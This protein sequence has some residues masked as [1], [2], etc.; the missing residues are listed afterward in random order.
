MYGE[1]FND[2]RKKYK[3]RLN[4]DEVINLL[5][6]DKVRIYIIENGDY[7]FLALI[8]SSNNDKLRSFYFNEQT[9]PYIIQLDKFSGVLF[10]SDFFPYKIK[11]FDNDLFLKGLTL[12]HNTHH[13]V[14]HI[15]EELK[16]QCDNSDLTN[17][18]KDGLYKFMYYLKQDFISE[19]KN[20]SIFMKEL[21][22]EL[23]TEFLDYISDD[24]KLV[25][26]QNKE[27]MFDEIFSNSFIE[28]GDILFEDV[29]IIINKFKGI[30]NLC[31]SPSL[32]YAL[33]NKSVDYNGVVINEQE[34]KRLKDYIFNDYC[35]EM[36]LKNLDY[37]SLKILYMCFSNEVIDYLLDDEGLIIIE[38]NNR[39]DKLLSNVIPYDELTKSK[40]FAMLLSKNFTD[41]QVYDA[42]IDR[43]GK[44]FSNGESF[45]NLLN[46]YI[47]L[48]DYSHFFRVFTKLSANT[49][50]FYFKNNFERLLELNNGE[51]CKG[52][53]KEVY[54]LFKDRVNFS[55]YVFSS[56]DL[57]VLLKHKDS[58]SLEQLERIFSNQE[59]IFAILNGKYI[60][61]TYEMI[62]N[63]NISKLNQIYMSEEVL[64]FLRNSNKLGRIYEI[65]DKLEIDASPLLL[66][67]NCLI[68]I[69]ETVEN[70]YKKS[71]LSGFNKFPQRD[72]GNAY[73]YFLLRIPNLKDDNT[74]F[75]I[76]DFY[77][78]RPK[79]LSTFHILRAGVK[80]E[81]L[82]EYLIS[83]RKLITEIIQE[84]NCD[85][86]LILGRLPDDIRK[87]EF[88]KG[89]ENVAI[90]LDALDYHG[91]FRDDFE[92]KYKLDE[93][94]LEDDRFIEKFIGY[95]SDVEESLRLV[96][97]DE[98]L[99]KKMLTKVKLYS[100]MKNKIARSLNDSESEFKTY[101]EIL[102]NSSIDVYGIEF[103]KDMIDVVFFNKCVKEVFFKYKNMNLEKIK[104]EFLSNVIKS[105]RE[106]IASS[107][108]NP[109]DKNIVYM[110]YILNG[111]K[112]LIPTIIYDSETYTFLVRRMRSGKHFY[113][114]TYKGG[115][116]YYSTITEKNRSMYYGETGVKFGYVRVIPEDIIQVNSF[117]A[118]SR[119]S[120]SNKYIAPYIKYPEWVSMEELNK[121]T[122]KSRSYNE[123]RIKEKY[124]PDFV[125][126][127]DEPNEATLRYSNEHS[128]PMVKILRK[129]YPGAIEQCKDPY[130]N[131]Q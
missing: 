5:L 24:L 51:I 3:N 65:V 117:D 99:I 105:S 62:L 98:M 125:I 63:L 87:S 39:F 126:S 7:N 96:T 109:L 127:Y 37:W 97:D 94:I 35:K 118:I 114:G 101:L 8:A 81:V 102:M 73:F 112:V 44:S 29:E 10:G 11:L 72:V 106:N 42:K 123:L 91:L 14:S 70:G 113:D 52:M 17:V 20:I 26:I 119:N 34:L 25:A 67:T 33:I 77:L 27:M 122:L 30:D 76:L 28:Y 88:F 6:D 16:K 43:I 58:Y 68:D 110:E 95:Y 18:L 50:L 4:E 59:N 55:D 82:Q 79:Y 111:E 129:G 48:R 128:T 93:K 54:E 47:E 15:G 19:V 36:F 115:I 46:R 56:Y 45:Y 69:G 124:I 89:R 9:I 120:R 83:R 41:I 104:L 92:G 84:N 107:I 57:S 71:S 32:L 131:C 22:S 23:Y 12:G 21:P 61:S 1:S 103:L 86:S 85:L 31:Y 49:Q 130:S 38:N 75:K 66:N 90:H 2:F 13:V 100:D 80:K 121:R 53:K 108:T 40:K 60:E 64:S 78:V 74:L 116:G